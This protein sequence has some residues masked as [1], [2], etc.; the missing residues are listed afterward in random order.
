MTEAWIGGPGI[1]S[2][3]DASDTWFLGTMKQFTFNQKG[4]SHLYI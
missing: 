2:Y 3:A 4:Y 1:P